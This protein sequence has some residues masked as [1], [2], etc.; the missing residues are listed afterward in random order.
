MDLSSEVVVEM[1]PEKKK[2]VK[3]GKKRSANIEAVFLH[4]L[5]DALGSIGAIASAC[6]INF[7]PEEQGWKYYA[8]PVCSLFIVFLILTN[9]IP[10]FKSVLGI[11]LQSAPQSVDMNKLA[12]S[13]VKIPGVEYFH[14]L[15][16]WQLNE[17]ITVATVHIICSHGFNHQAVMD[18][19]K[20]LFHACKIHSST[21]QIEIVHD[22]GV[23]DVCN[24][25]VC[26]DRN[27]LIRNCCA[28]SRIVKEC[29][30]HTPR[31]P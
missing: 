5:S 18:D 21:V 10:L 2:P 19:V 4:V 15:H 24:D 20:K 23:K 27:C 26:N 9:S 25:I 30:E 17:D 22:E 11:L 29:S 31:S 6:L 1:E 28:P 7:L 12:E 13:L 3:K 16:V 14:G 8:D